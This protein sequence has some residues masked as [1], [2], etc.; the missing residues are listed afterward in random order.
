MALEA[1]GT[2]SDEAYVDRLLEHPAPL[3]SFTRERQ[4]GVA[5]RSQ[6]ELDKRVRLMPELQ[7]KC[8]A[9]RSPYVTLTSL[10]K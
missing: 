8:A 9:S 3:L 1:A 2:E 5:I 4:R 10:M 7:T 6:G